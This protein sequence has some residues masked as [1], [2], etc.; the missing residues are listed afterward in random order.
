MQ[1]GSPL[2]SGNK[3]NAPA[4]ACQKI[5]IVVF[6]L[7]KRSWINCKNVVWC[8]AILL[9]T[10]GD[11]MWKV[12]Y[13][14]QHWPYRIW[15]THRSLVN[16]ARTTWLVALWIHLYCAIHCKLEIANWKG[17]FD[18]SADLFDHSKQDGWSNMAKMDSLDSLDSKLAWTALKDKTNMLLLLRT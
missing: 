15:R 9:N 14:Y 2:T 17:I 7:S 5:F 4:Q 8:I 18:M 16:Y 11:I 13:C 6:T 10:A 3:F 12:R 1:K